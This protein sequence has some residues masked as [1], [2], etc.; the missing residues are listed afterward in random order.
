MPVLATVCVCQLHVSSQAETEVGEKLQY[1]VFV[2]ENK[3]LDYSDN[4][5]YGSIKGPSLEKY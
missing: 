5:C 3:N 1:V 2:V 4:L